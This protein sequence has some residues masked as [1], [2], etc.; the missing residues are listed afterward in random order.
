[1]YDVRF[2]LTGLNSSNKRVFF[3]NTTA[4]IKA[5]EVHMVK[6]QL[7]ELPK[8]D[9]VLHVQSFSGPPIDEKKELYF[10]AK[11]HSTIIQL[12]KAVY[13][14][15]DK[16]QFRVLFFD[17]ATKPMVIKENLN[18]HISD[19]AE[20]RI[21][22]WTKQSVAQGVFKGELQLSSSPILGSWCLTAVIGDGV[23]R[24]CIILA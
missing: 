10:V 5:N 20:N 2:N 18:I 17:A 9:Y 1:V 16:V 21:K 12:D 7:D 23:V 3:K 6:I 15:G 14:P 24:M 13:K 11:T 22:Q 4:Q 8:A 19:K